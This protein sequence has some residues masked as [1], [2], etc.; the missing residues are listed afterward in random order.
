MDKDMYIT[1]LRNLKSII[2][3][4]KEME[5]IE[6]EDILEVVEDLKQ[7]REVTPRFYN[8]LVLR[9]DR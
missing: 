9:A 4:L 8:M 7:I 1:N 3:W 2:D 5:M 6:Q